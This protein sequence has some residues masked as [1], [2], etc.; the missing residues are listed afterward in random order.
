MEIK[1]DYPGTHA[2]AETL[3][4]AASDLGMI[5]GSLKVNKDDV[6]TTWHGESAAAFGERLDSCAQNIKLQAQRLEVLSAD[7][8]AYADAYEETEKKIISGVNGQGVG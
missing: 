3:K 1:I 4:S 2:A 8:K 5:Y 6:L 7:I